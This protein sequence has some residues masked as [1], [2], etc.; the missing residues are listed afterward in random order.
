MQL[1]VT[2]FVNAEE[3][4]SNYLSDNQVPACQVLRDTS[5]PC[6]YNTVVISKA[7]RFRADLAVDKRNFCSRFTRQ[8]AQYHMPL[9]SGYIVRSLRLS[10]AVRDYANHF[11]S[12]SNG[13]YVTTFYPVCC[14]KADR[15]LYSDLQ[16]SACLFVTNLIAQEY[17]A[18]VSS[19][20]FLFLFS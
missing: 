16:I 15:K 13:S 14:K 10:A 9:R 20:G 17:I 5:L 3:G 2:L 6:V 19:A 1:L 7:E 11:I 18:T 12:H 4:N 8:M